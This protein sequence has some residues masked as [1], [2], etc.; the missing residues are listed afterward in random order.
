MLRY[1]QMRVGGRLATSNRAGY[2][3]VLAV[4]RASGS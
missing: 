3:I 2:L 1:L 4:A